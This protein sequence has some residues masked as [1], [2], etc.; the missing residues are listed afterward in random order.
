MT[1]LLMHAFSI[2]KTGQGVIEYAKSLIK[3]EFQLYILSRHL[4][5]VSTIYKPSIKSKKKCV[6]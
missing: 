3:R 4:S 5:F 2:S 1:S 6:G